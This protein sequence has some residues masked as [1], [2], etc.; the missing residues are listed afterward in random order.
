MKVGIHLFHRDLR[1]YD[2]TALYELDKMCDA[3]LP[4]FIFDPVQ[5]QPSKN[6]YFSSN[7]VQ[8]MVESLIDL[9]EQLSKYG[10]NT[11][12]LYYG[13]PL[14][15]LRRL[16]Q[17][18]PKGTV[19][20]LSMNRDYTP[21][22]I[23]RDN[24]I[25]DWVKKQGMETVYS[26][27][28]TLLPVGSVRTTSSNEVFKVF[29]PF[30][31]A[32]SSVPVRPPSSEP[33]HTDTFRVPLVA[34]TIKSLSISIQKAQGFYKENPRVYIRGG[35]QN[36]LK[37]LTKLGNFSRYNQE[38]DRPSIPSTMLSAH[39][40]FGTIS[41][42]EFHRAVIDKLGK[43]NHL[44]TQ[45]FWRDFYYNIAFAYPRVFGHSF[46]PKYDAIKWENNTEKFRAWCQGRTGVPIIDAGMRQLNTTGFMHNRL[47]M[48]VSMYLVKDLH[49]DWRWGERYFAT[50]LIDY[51][52]AQN[53][54]GWQWSASTGTDSQPYFR[55]F[56]PYTMTAKVDADGTYIREW[57]PELSKVSVKDYAKWDN[58]R[59]RGKYDLVEL[60]YPENPIVDH[61][62]ERK[63]TLEM[64]RSLSS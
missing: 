3:I 32:A 13:N 47:R 56:N 48:M 30:F 53:N 45:I 18:F 43:A 40:K 8:F 60:G 59:T 61:D 62:V 49:I 9:K 10:C 64:F 20:A 23:K 12:L 39:N 37:I 41:I 29:T 15:V 25:L 27:D 57:V 4:V 52:P 2:N 5:I 55:I 21:F 50:Q 44:Y 42:R 38:R 16:C 54:G 26:D 58:E 17:S 14:D 35:R 46:R 19:V 1:L 6:S 33:Y 36:G 24:E 31:R 28:I 63:K 7:S 51:D 11:P 22:A 34:D